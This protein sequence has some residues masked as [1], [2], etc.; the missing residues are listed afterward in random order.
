MSRS[1]NDFLNMLQKL[2]F[3]VCLIHCN[4]FC[5]YNVKFLCIVKAL[6]RLGMQVAPFILKIQNML[7]LTNNAVSLF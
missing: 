6:F 3:N 5:I 2:V 7:F 4:C 1:N